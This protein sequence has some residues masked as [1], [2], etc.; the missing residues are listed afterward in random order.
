MEIARN[1][2]KVVEESPGRQ[3]HRIEQDEENVKMRKVFPLGEKALA[4]KTNQLDKKNLK[5]QKV[6]WLIVI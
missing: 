2:H 1:Q 6:L 3:G 4:L 5:I